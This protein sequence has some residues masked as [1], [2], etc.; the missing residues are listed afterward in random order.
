MTVFVNLHKKEPANVKK[1]PIE[2]VFKFFF[3]RDFVHF[4][5][6]GVVRYG[7]FAFSYDFAD[8]R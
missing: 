7:L 4:I 3:Y 8:S 5:D 6:V 1:I 2:E